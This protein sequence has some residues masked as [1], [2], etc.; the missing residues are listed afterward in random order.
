MGI[1]TFST[2]KLITAMNNTHDHLSNTSFLIILLDFSNSSLN[3]YY[4][5]SFNK[6]CTKFFP[7]CPWQWAVPVCLLPVCLFFEAF[8]STSVSVSPFKFKFFKAYYRSC[9]TP[10]H[11][12]YTV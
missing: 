12:I 1:L 5:H 3:L 9:Y 2:K 10:M 7:F 6:H 8:A 4:V 11:L